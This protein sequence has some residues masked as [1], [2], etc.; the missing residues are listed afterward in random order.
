VEERAHVTEDSFGAGSPPPANVIS[1][2]CDHEV[3]VALVVIVE[4][5]AGVT[6]TGSLCPAM[7]TVL[8]FVARNAG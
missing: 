3:A 4:H 5:V 1:G 2:S 7:A 8:V 6:T